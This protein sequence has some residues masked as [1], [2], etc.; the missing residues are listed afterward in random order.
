MPRCS[1]PP[2]SRTGRPSGGCSP[3]IPWW[4]SCANSPGWKPSCTRR[5]AASPIACASS[6][7]AST[8]RPWPSAPPRMSRGSGRCSRSCRP[9]RPRGPVAALLREYRIRRVTVDEILT[10]LRRPPLTVAPGTIDAAGAHIALLL[11]RL[12][13]AATQ[14]RLCA[15]RLEALL[16]TLAAVGEQQGHRDVT[17]L[18][19]FPGVGSAVAATTLAEPSQLLAT[20]HYHRLRA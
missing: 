15:Q 14:R 6:C 7:C 16:E 20:R 17:V 12:E 13:L 11:P 3:T 9:R 19:S 18:R 2:C 4:S 10:V 8:L 1:P 5:S